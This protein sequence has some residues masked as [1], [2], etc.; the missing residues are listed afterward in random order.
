MEAGDRWDRLGTGAV[1]RRLGVTPGAVSQAR[2]CLARSW[3]QFQADA[4]AV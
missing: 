4:E 1:A 3:G 2:E